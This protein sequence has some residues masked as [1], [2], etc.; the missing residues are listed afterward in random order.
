[1][2]GKCKSD[3]KNMKKKSATFDTPY[4]TSVE[5]DRHDISVTSDVPVMSV[6]NDTCI[7]VPVTHSA[8]LCPRS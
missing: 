5:V 3:V 6:S 4:Y 1:M 8:R 7:G 2:I